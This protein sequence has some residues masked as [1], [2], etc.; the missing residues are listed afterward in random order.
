VSE[1]LCLELFVDESS[2]VAI[3]EHSGIKF[4]WEH[5]EIWMWDTEEE[6]VAQREA[7]QPLSGDVLCVGYGLGLEQRFLVENERVNS[8]LTIERSPA[9]IEGCRKVYGEI[10]GEVEICD[11][12]DYN[13]DRR[14]DFVAVDIWPEVRSIYV[15]LYRRARDKCRTFLK[16]GGEVAAWGGD[17]YEFK[18]LGLGKSS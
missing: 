14:F 13:T 1:E 8:V 6:I 11:L 15:D 18:L 7:A 17:F 4:L 3:T 5:K 12:F 2:G 9:V 10:Y 16:P